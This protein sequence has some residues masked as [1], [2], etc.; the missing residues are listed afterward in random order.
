MIF[1]YLGKIYGQ[2]KA[3]L[4]LRKQR[5]HERKV[6]ESVAEV[7]VEIER[8]CTEI[9]TADR[10]FSDAAR[11]RAYCYART[12]VPRTQVSMLVNSAAILTAMVAASKM[13]VE[14]TLQ[15]S[16]LSAYE[17]PQCV[18][19]MLQLYAKLYLSDLDTT[20]TIYRH[21]MKRYLMSVLNGDSPT[22]VLSVSRLASTL[23]RHA[24]PAVYSEFLRAIN[25]VHVGHVYSLTTFLRI[26]SGDSAYNTVNLEGA[27]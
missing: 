20:H 2:L 24:T 12:P 15:S 25:P 21:T 18:S 3:A 10:V 19:S 16:R 4:R 14:E 13:I 5:K 1:K 26:A 22:A 17:L 23:S 6:F 7:F 11:L 27:P 8:R 9:R